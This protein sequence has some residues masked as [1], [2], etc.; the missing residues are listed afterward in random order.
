MVREPNPSIDTEDA[1]FTVGKGEKVNLRIFLDK[2][3][4]E[5][6]ANDRQC[7]TQVIYPTLGDAIHIQVFA[8]DAPIRVEELKTWKIFPA[9]QW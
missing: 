4:V 2:S 6:F 3:I 7:L 5:V 8:D 9:M 1:P